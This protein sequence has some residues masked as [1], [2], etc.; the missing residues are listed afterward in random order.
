MGSIP[1]SMSGLS[2]L[3]TPGGLLSNLP[4]PV[5]PSDLSSASPQDLVTISAAALEAQVVDSL[6]GGSQP[7][8]TATI[9]LPVTSTGQGT[10]LPGVSSADL[11][12]A[13]A[14]Q[15]TAINVEA[16][17]LQQVESL[18]GQTA[19]TTGTVSLLG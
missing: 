4:S 14:Q 16:L 2:Y 15:Q 13:T 18:F 1:S 8:S 3:T 10:V 17:L 12:N 7:G 5:S 11:I 19:S 6:F 9:S